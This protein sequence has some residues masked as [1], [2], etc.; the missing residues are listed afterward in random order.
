MKKLGTSNFLALRKPCTIFEFA[1]L[2][3]MFIR[4]VYKMR[5]K[6]TKRT[7]KSNKTCRQLPLQ[8]RIATTQQLSD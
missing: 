1:K 4:H 2:F 7:H 8:D 3:A 6:N 5:Q